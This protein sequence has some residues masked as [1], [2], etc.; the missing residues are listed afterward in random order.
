MLISQFNPSN[1]GKGME[2]LFGNGNNLL[3]LVKLTDA[4]MA[5]YIFKEVKN[6]ADK[7]TGSTGKT[8]LPFITSRAEAQKEA[9]QLNVINQSVIGAKKVWSKPSP[10]WSAATSPMPSS[11]R[12][13]AVTTKASTTSLYLE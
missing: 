4:T 13:M 9:N 5:S 1:P 8:V 2:K 11:G 6:R 10:S 12:Q 7:L 3:M